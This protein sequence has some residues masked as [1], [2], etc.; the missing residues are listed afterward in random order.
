MSPHFSFGVG[1][2]SHAAAFAA[3]LLVLM[4][5][6]S[7]CVH[8]DQHKHMS[9]RRRALTKTTTATKTE[10][11]LEKKTSRK[12]QWP[13]PDGRN[14]HKI[15]NDSRDTL[16]P[17]PSPTKEPTRAQPTVPAAGTVYLYTD[18]DET[19]NRLPRCHG[20]CDDDDDCR[21]GLVCYQRST[22]SSK[23]VY[24]CE[25]RAQGGKDYCIDPADMPGEPTASPTTKPTATPTKKATPAPTIRVTDPPSPS[26]TRSPTNDPT[27]SPTASPTAGP[28]AA[29]VV[30]E[31][32]PIVNVP[33]DEIKEDDG[34]GDDTTNTL[35]S[36]NVTTPV[37]EFALGL[38]Y[39]E[40]VVVNSVFTAIIT[41]DLRE[42]MT[43][44]LDQ[45]VGA[46]IN[47]YD[48]LVFEGVDLTVMPST[49]NRRRRLRRELQD[50][51]DGGNVA[52]FDIGGSANLQVQ[53]DATSGEE[54]DDETQQQIQD[55]V[56]SAVRAAVADKDKM[57]SYI[58][59][60]ASTNLL[61]ALEGVEDPI[62]ADDSGRGGNVA[63]A[64]N[65]GNNSSNGASVGQ[66]VGF[67][68]VG[69]MAAGL[70]ATGF[71]LYKRRQ[72]ERR[73]ELEANSMESTNHGHVKERG[74]FMSETTAGHDSEDPRGS[75]SGFRLVPFGGSKKERGVDATHDELDSS[76]SA[77]EEYGFD[78][79]TRDDDTFAQEL[80][81][82]ATVD[83]RAWEE[84]DSLRD[85]S[86]ADFGWYLLVMWF[87]FFVFYRL[88]YFL[89]IVIVLFPFHHNSYYYVAP[90]LSRER[91][92]R[93]RMFL[94]SHRLTLMHRTFSSRT[95]TT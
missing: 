20:D 80:Q 24:G 48:G 40:E 82:A 64:S 4:A 46:A 53:T 70:L 39:P 78:E 41:E 16:E 1:R 58:R 28:T 77:E 14:G 75:G 91:L 59:E 90:L 2:R 10:Q 73:Q 57:M 5:L 8:A 49:S 74:Q 51:S 3:A 42:V 93:T 36:V 71:V 29:P 27:V 67:A 26:P 62:F 25:G 47:N 13:W 92:L 54:L 11:N 85:V 63:S 56:D 21:S 65:G 12:L 23:E 60:H 50:A 87:Y 15:T 34:A 69:V 84:L 72:Y 18:D 9:N 83:K 79:G 17:T 88:H 6:S 81:D 22:D 76:S 19:P 61:K 7:C 55:K 32:P 52:K 95:K 43:G 33:V 86:N 37:P 66:V 68:L 35:R 31:V 38:T 44:Y 45:E 30:S 94:R 89:T